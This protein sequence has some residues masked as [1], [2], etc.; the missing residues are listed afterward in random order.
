M[1]LWDSIND[2]CWIPLDWLWDRGIPI[3][4]IFE[5]YNLPAVL[6]PL[7]II[8]V[9]LLV[10]WL[11]MMPA[12][13][14]ACGDGQC[15]HEEDCLSCP[16][17]CGECAPPPAEKL[18][19]TVDLIGPV[20]EPVALK[21][22]DK[23]DNIIDSVTGRNALFEFT[24]IEPQVIKAT[25]TC[26]NG[27]EQSSR[28]K[29]MDRDDSTISL[30]L[31]NG[32]FDYITDNSNIPVQTHG[33]IDVRVMDRSTQDPIDARVTVV[34]HVDNLPEDA[35]TTIGGSATINVRADKFYYLT[36]AK[37]AYQSYDGRSDRFFVVG[38]DTI[39]RTVE[40]SPVPSS[41]PSPLRVCAVSG[42]GPLE[43]G[44]I[45]V[46]EVGGMELDSASLNPSDAGCLTFQLPSGKLV[47]A[48][49]ISPPSG[50]VAPDPSDPVT[51]GPGTDE[52]ELDVSCGQETALVKVIIYDK[53]GNIRTD[54]VK[55]T[56]WDA[57]DKEQ[58]PGTAPDSSLSMGI[59]G[60]TEDVRVPAGILIQ[61][62][63]A[64]VPLG[65]VDTV[66][67]PV[68]FSP[69]ESGTISI[70]LGEQGR[71]GFTFLGA[72]IIY[73]P[74]TPGSPVKVFVQQILYNQTVLTETNSEVL[75]LIE[76]REYPAMYN[77]S[78][79]L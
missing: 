28:P 60:Y 27:K 7:M 73:T 30:S 32:C 8:L 46:I 59:G 56:L 6:F 71:G 11:L 5:K 33:N 72:S 50:C 1:A 12:A 34:R 37:P 63:A 20:L 43:S 36:A 51:T 21:L 65:Y 35:A 48:S 49:L 78:F 38:G 29:A 79:A 44:R 61:A 62:K 69:D 40:L 17:D 57:V 77:S 23:N 2:K 3:G 25:V 45:S 24:N 14:Q 16:G 9:V 52:I 54:E 39:Y 67:G 75:I 74:A 19:I 31:P 68:A 22:F 26:P 41:V 70:V 55:I 18:I 66:S 58:I 4:R 42:S 15:G 76:G 64:G 13:V 47:R 53:E 10:V